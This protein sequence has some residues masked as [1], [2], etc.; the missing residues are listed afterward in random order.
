MRDI[1]LRALDV[2]SGVDAVLAEDTRVTS[3]LL[4]HHGISTRLIAMHEHNERRM[5]PRVLALLAEGKSVAVVSDAGTPGISDPGAALV[6]AVVNAGLRVVPVPGPSAVVT[7]L[8]VAG[9]NMPHFMFYGFLPTRASARKRELAGLG[10]LPYPLVFFEAP[11]RVVDSVTDMRD[12]LGGTRRIVIARELTKLFESVHVCSLADAVNW[13]EEDPDRC[14]GEFVLVLA[15]EQKAR[16]GRDDTQNR[17]VLEVLLS[18]M[19][20][21]RAVML[22][23]RITGAGR[24]ELYALALQ[25]KEA[26]NP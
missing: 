19:P 1:S 5:I 10:E 9:L 25:L 26:R 15:G 20:L 3:R 23:S 14:R 8:C 6:A 12:V 24:N 17:C 13:L 4:N 2:L 11:H 21:K 7:A 18:E 22:A 16:A